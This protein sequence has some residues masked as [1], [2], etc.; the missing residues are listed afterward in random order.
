MVKYGIALGVALVLNA[1]ANLMIRFGMRALDLEL[2]GA[3]LLD[4]GLMGLIRLLLKHWIVLLGIC[5]FAANVVFYAY[6][7][8]KLQISV[9]YPI[10]VTGGFAIIVVV[11]G[12]MLR[13]RLSL[14]QW[15]GVGA[16]LI[17][18]VLVAKDAGRQ[19]GSAPTAD[20]TPATGSG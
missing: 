4:G 20:E 9:A 5:C 2:A 16:I 8:Q 1:C 11:A 7:L 19:M 13:E 18:V 14:L 6:A 3:G 10:M 15:V 12:I 17:G